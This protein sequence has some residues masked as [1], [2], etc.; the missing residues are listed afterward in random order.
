MAFSS[1]A[2]EVYKYVGG[3][4]PAANHTEVGAEADGSICR[5]ITPTRTRP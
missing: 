4:F 5:S 3:V 1:N 2:E